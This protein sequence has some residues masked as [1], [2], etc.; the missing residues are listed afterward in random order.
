MSERWR[1]GCWSTTRPDLV[2]ERTRHQNRL[3]WHLVE[4]DAELEV[5]LPACALDRERWLGRRDC[6]SSGRDR[7]SSGT[8]DPR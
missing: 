8:P 3:R 7:H 5:S 4:L 1:S 2:A 6:P